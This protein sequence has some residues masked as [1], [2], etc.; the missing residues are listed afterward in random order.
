[1]GGRLCTAE[2]LIA[3]GGYDISLEGLLHIHAEQVRKEQGTGYFYQHNLLMSVLAL[4]QSSFFARTNVF[5]KYY[6][7]EFGGAWHFEMCMKVREKGLRVLSTPLADLITPVD[8]ALIDD[9]ISRVTP[10]QAQQFV[11]RWGKIIYSVA[12]SPSLEP[13][14]GG[15]VLRQKHPLLQKRS[16]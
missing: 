13:V 3:G 6:C 16:T 9:E 4:L 8:S 7:A 2:G 11:E 12:I 14:S 15:Y 10:Q 1:M 5:Q